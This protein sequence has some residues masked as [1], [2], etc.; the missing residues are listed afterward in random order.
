MFAPAWNNEFNLPDGSYS[1]CNIQ[2]YFEYII[3]KNA[4]LLQVILPYKSM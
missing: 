2:H 1:V 3:K 4:K